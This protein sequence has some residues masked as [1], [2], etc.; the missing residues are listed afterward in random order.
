MAKDFWETKAF[1]QWSKKEYEKILND[2]PWAKELNL[3]GVNEI[4]TGAAAATDGRPPYIKYKILLRSAAP[5]RQAIVRKEQINNQ[6]D[7]LPADQKLAFDQS[8]EN[9]LNDTSPELVIV[10]ISFET[11]NLDYLCDL[12]RHWEIQSTD[13]LK[14]SVYLSA[15]KGEKV[16]ILQFIPGNSASQEFQFIFPR[17]VNGK[18]IL[19]PGGKTLQLEFAYPVI[20][21]LGDGRGFIEFKTDKMKINNKVVY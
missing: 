6:Y 21:E 16:P 4:F 8:T 9:F 1:N 3:T 11:N 5:V 15:S 13:L 17:E 10:S 12:N 7:S 2:S 20:D 14:N 18:E 19:Q